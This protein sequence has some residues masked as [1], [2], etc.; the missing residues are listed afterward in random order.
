MPPTMAIRAL[1]CS[2]CAMHCSLAPIALLRQKSEPHDWQSRGSCSAN[3]SHI[4][5]NDSHAPF[6]C[7]SMVREQK[8]S[9]HES[10]PR[11]SFLQTLLRPTQFFRVDRPLFLGNRIATREWF[12][13][14][15]KSRIASL[16]PTVKDEAQES[17]T[18]FLLYRKVMLD[19]LLALVPENNSQPFN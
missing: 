6:W 16:V 1:R 15:N 5:T 13:G 19:M 11:H 12:V 9:A 18:P 4:I 10:R 14:L 8:L 3:I 2:I 7:S 17:S